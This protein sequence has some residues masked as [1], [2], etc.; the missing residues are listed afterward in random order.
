[1]L[2]E[3]PRALSLGAAG[4][5]VKPVARDALLHAI[6]GIG[7]QLHRVVGVSVLLVGDD[8]ADLRDIW[9]TLHEVGCHV[10]R[11]A[12]LTRPMTD[13][14]LDIAI[15]VPSEGVPVPPDG[16]SAM[17]SAPVMLFGA[18]VD[19]DGL[20]A[21]RSEDIQRP[22]VLVRRLRAVLDRRAGEAVSE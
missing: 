9:E 20:F 14:P 13:T 5:L 12:R 16:G 22:E 7:V 10:E 1:M 19:Q 11:S 4:Y 2:D 21:L 3:A 18:D 15:L 8:S 6:E 17:V